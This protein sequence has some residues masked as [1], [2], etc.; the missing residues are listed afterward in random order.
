MSVQ[1]GRSAP[2]TIEAIISLIAW[3]I[4]K[5]IGNERIYRM[6]FQ[7]RLRVSRV[8]EEFLIGPVKRIR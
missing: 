6:F 7:H 4:D 5:T 8:Y 2:D 1:G 3:S